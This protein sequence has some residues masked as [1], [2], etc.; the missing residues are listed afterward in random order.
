M[1]CK[2]EKMTER[3]WREVS[4]I[5]LEGINTGRSTFQTEV[6][7]WPDWDNSHIKSC[8]LIACL[9]NRVL[10]WAALS[11]ISSRCVYAGVAEV[12][13]YIGKEY[14]GKGMGTALLKNLIKLSEQSGF[15]TLQSAVIKENTGSIALHKKCG[16]RK[17][18][19]REKLGKMNNGLWHDVVLMERRSKLVGVN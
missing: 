17:I 4:K 6:P 14:R 2:I 8:R 18:G 3:H 10:G 13:I 19:I 7:K 5:Y 12:S 16:F 9:D 15:W 11:P 1:N